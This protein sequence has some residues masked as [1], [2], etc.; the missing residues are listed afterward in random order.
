MAVAVVGIFSD[1]CAVLGF[2]FDLFVFAVVDELAVFGV[3]F[4]V[5]GIV[6]RVRLL[7]AF[8]NRRLSLLNLL[9]SGRKG[10]AFPH[11]GRPSRGWVLGSTNQ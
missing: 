10:R 6:E 11:I 3:E 8:C 5:S 4:G 9:V 1:G 2:D 7:D